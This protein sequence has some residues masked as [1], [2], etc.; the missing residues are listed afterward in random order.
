MDG[1]ALLELAAELRRR[2]TNHT[3]EHLSEMARARVAHVKR[4]LN[5][6]ARRFADELLRM[7]DAFARNETQRRHASRL[8]E[9][10]RE[11]E[12]TELNELGQHFDR[13]LLGEM[14]RDE[15]PHLLKLADRQSPTDLW[16]A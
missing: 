4:D 13:D 9:D 3:P 10:T 8:L 14:F 12:G 15:I 11:V 5:Q 6:A 2:Y 7:G 1:S 16:F